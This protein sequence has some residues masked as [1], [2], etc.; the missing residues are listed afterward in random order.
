MKKQTKLT[1]AQQALA[2]A[3][4]AMLK[5]WATVPKFARTVKP[6]AVKKPPVVIEFHELQ[7]ARKSLM[8]PGGSTALKPAAKYTGTEM[9]GVAQM[10]K[11]N[12][13]PIFNPVAAVE[14]TQMRRG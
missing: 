6:P 3:D 5:R 1:K 7:L 9:I 13:V 11:S 4:E 14:V 12:A 2:A 8:T 10:H